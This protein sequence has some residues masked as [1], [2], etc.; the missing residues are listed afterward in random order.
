MTQTPVRT[1]YGRPVLKEPEWTWEVPWYLFAGG[2]AG[3]ASMVVPLARARGDEAL[4]VRAEALAAAGAVAGPALLVADLGRPAR[5]L[6]MLRVFRP[7]SAMSVG[8]WVLAAWSGSTLARSGLGVVGRLPRVRRLLDG[9][10]GLLGIPMATYTGVLMADTSIPVWH[11]ARA[12][13]PTVFAASGAASAGAALLLLDPDDAVGR[14]LA[15]GGAVVEL[16]AD[17]VMERRLGELGEVYATGDAGTWGKAAKV[18][19]ASGAL[20]VAAGGGRRGALARTGA[21]LLL[22]G[23]VCLRWSVYRAGFQSAWDPVHT[24][25]PQRE[26]LDRGEGHRSP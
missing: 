13:L 10:A 2:L 20:L 23:G 19:A 14:R 1:Y 7:T 18:C 12:E 8:S 21:A 4:A 26:R 25:K 9:A 5:F 22:A 24:V 15:L 16:A 6:N 17:Q 11:E 3:V